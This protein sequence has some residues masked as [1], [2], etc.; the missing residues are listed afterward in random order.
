VLIPMGKRSF[1]HL[2]VFITTC[3]SAYA[4][5]AKA[6]FDF[7]SGSDT[8]SFEYN[9]TV[10]TGL[11]V[12]ALTKNGVASRSSSGNFRASSWTTGASNGSNIVTGSLDSSDYFEVAFTAQPGFSFSVSLIEF[13]VGRSGTGP[14][15]AAWASD[16]SYAALLP[17]STVNA[18]LAHSDGVLTMPDQ[19][20]GFTGN[21]VVLSGLDYSGLQG[22][23]TF[24]CY[25]WNAEA[26]TGTGG[27]QGNLSFT[28]SVVPEPSSYAGLVGVWVF[29]AAALRRREKR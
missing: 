28:V 8:T 19:D 4:D 18:N 21:S 14:R 2:V 29:C 17:V 23:R 6:T 16:V 15:N 3:I 10:I 24:R 13:G 7:A 11:T 20:A 9:G 26:G 27:L 22:S 5:L 25:M 1:L 12:S